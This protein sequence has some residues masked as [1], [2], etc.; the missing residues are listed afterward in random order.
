MMK[1]VSESRR[2]RSGPNPHNV[3]TSGDGVFV[4]GR[5]LLGRA[6]L[7]DLES[8]RH[9]VSRLPERLQEQR[10]LVVADHSEAFCLPLVVADGADGVAENVG[11]GLLLVQ[12]IPG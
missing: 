1:T 9:P 11:L 12:P 8:P 3:R 5:L 2:P 7:L 10:L 4:F 6:P